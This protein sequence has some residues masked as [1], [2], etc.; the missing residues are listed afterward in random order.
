MI[1]KLNLSWII[2]YLLF[3]KKKKILIN[4]KNII[5]RD[6]GE[7]F[8]GNFHV[9]LSTSVPVSHIPPFPLNSPP[10]FSG[11]CVSRSLVLCVCF[12]DRCLSFC[13]F[14]FGLFV[15]CSSL[16]YR[17][18]LPLWYLQTLITCQTSFLLT[19]NIKHKVNTCI[20]RI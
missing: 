3:I 2:F 19:G 7:K 16:M 6:S 4:T 20:Y 8:P 12:V 15:V 13:T 1:R 11:V 17:F 5:V 18:W 10:G 9:F 14:S